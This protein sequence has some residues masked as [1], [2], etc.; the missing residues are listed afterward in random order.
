MSPGRN[1]AA[2]ASSSPRADVSLRE[3]IA[4]DMRAEIQKVQATATAT[5]TEQL[6]KQVEQAE[7]TSRRQAEE[8]SALREREAAALAS[9][10]S[11]KFRGAAKGVLSVLATNREIAEA[12][13][14]TES[15]VL[16]AQNEAAAREMVSPCRD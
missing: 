11:A 9:S 6:R 13:R 1:P 5:A 10:A 8:L 15:L 7:E 12:R 16:E 3:A 4:Q 14:E 2:A